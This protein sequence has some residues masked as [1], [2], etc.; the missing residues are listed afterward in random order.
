MGISGIKSGFFVVFYAMIIAFHPAD[1]SPALCA[2]NANM[3]DRRSGD[4]SAGMAYRVQYYDLY[5]ALDTLALIHQPGLN[6]AVFPI[7][8]RVDMHLATTGMNQAAIKQRPRS[9]LDFDAGPQLVI[10]SLFVDQQQMAFRHHKSRVQV[11]LES[12]VRKNVNAPCILTVF[13]HARLIPAVKP[14]WEDGVVVSSDDRGR[15]WIGMTCQ[16][17]GASAWWPCMDRLSTEP[18]SVRLTFDL[19]QNGTVLVT[20]GQQAPAERLPDGRMRYRALVSY[21]INLYNITFNIAHYESF[22][23]PYRDSEGKD[24]SLEFHMLEGGEE[25]AKAYFT[26]AQTMMEG[27]EQVFGPY[28][29][30]RDGYKL[31]ETPY[32]GMEHQSCVAYGNHLKRNKYGFDFI[33]VHESAHE[34]WGNAV[35]A[36]RPH[37]LWIHEGLATW[38]ESRLLEWRYPDSSLYID[39]MVGLRDRIH[40]KQPVAAKKGTHKRQLDTDVYY[41]AAWMW[42]GIRHSMPSKSRFDEA[43]RQFYQ[44]YTYKNLDTRALTNFWCAQLGASY[45]GIFDHYLYRKHLPVLVCDKIGIDSEGVYTLK[46][47][48]RRVSRSFQMGID[49]G[50]GHFIPQSRKKTMVRVRGDLENFSANLQRKYLMDVQL[51]NH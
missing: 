30:W 8:G 25:Q 28:A 6:K 45:A 31:V 39:Y 43:L 48:L 4:C 5:M 44:Q 18:D 32:W 1:C 46:T 27:F 47:H 11:D 34:W 33:L 7:S 15:P 36:C 40:N 37:D 23:L 12:Y 49:F 22:T 13:F 41:K 38:S 2:F 29:F 9:V 3:H 50:G 26:E 14:P 17:S 24:Q 51:K 21:P 19:P 10:D 42:H 35:S 20:N 16:T